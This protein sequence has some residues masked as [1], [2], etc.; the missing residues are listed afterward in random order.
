MCLLVLKFL[1]ITTMT[2]FLTFTVQSNIPSESYSSHLSPSSQWG[3]RKRVDSV[4]LLIEMEAGSHMNLKASCSFEQPKRIS[5]EKD[6]FGNRSGAGVSPAPHGIVLQPGW[7]FTV[8]KTSM[9]RIF[10]HH[11]ECKLIAKCSISE[12]EHFSSWQLYSK[13]KGTDHHQ[14]CVHQ[15]M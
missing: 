5:M 9:N 15:G 6:R 4:R 1:R 10:G 12:S 13:G 14:P 7:Y 8:S 2:F 11:Q 3:F